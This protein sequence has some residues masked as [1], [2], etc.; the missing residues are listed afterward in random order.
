MSKARGHYPLGMSATAVSPS[1]ALKEVP[2]DACGSS[3]ETSASGEN[4]TAKPDFETVYAEHFRFVWRAVRGLG[5]GAAN[6]DDVTQEV[7]LV[8]HRRLSTLDDPRALQAWLFQ[9]A[10][11]VTKDHRRAL[12]RRGESVSLDPERAEH[13]AQDPERQHAERQSMALVAAYADGLDEERRALF[14]LALVEGLP[15][16][17]VAN[18]IGSNPNTTYS[19]VRVMRREL[20]ELLE[21]PAAKG[22][23]RGPA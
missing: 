3:R 7:F 6:V 5:V 21:Q 14:F 22:D 10:R 18:L 9:I 2:V 23:S 13:R 4:V 8:V 19:R 11:R 17:E 12:G 1:V 15:I 16:A 20:A